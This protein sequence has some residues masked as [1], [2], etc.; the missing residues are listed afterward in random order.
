MTNNK[1]PITTAP[2]Q[3]AEHDDFWSF[4][5]KFPWSWFPDLY[6]G[7]SSSTAMVIPYLRRTAGHIGGRQP[8]E[9]GHPI[10][11]RRSPCHDLFPWSGDRGIGVDS[12]NHQIGIDDQPAAFNQCLN[13]LTISSSLQV[14]PASGPK[15]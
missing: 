6:R 12:M 9:F 8:L 14:H 15:S 11:Y 3:P 13:L 7:F 4:Y 10:D 2:G 5:R 1:P